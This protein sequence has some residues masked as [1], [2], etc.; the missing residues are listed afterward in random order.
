MDAGVPLPL[1]DCET[2]L[3]PRWVTVPDLVVRG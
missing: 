2:W 1:F 3:F